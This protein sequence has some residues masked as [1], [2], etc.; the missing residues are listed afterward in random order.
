[1]L[2]RSTAIALCTLSALFMH[3]A[4]ATADNYPSRQITLVVPFP[5]GGASDAITRILAD[6]LGESLRSTIVVENK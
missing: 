3:G 2:F 6:K 5:A 1:M 4:S